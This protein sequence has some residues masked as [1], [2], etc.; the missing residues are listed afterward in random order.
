MSHTKKPSKLEADQRK[1]VIDFARKAPSKNRLSQRTK[2]SQ[3]FGSLPGLK[4]AAYLEFIGDALKIDD[5][6]FRVHEKRAASGTVID[7]KEFINFGSYDYLALNGDVRVHQAAQEAIKKYGVSASA[8]RLVA[9]ERP[10]HTALEQAL[11]EHYKVEDAIVFVSGHATNVSTIGTLMTDKDLVIHDAYAHDSIMVGIKLSGATRRSFKHNDYDALEA[12]LESNQGLFKNTMVCVEGLYSMDGD[13]C[14]LP[15]LLEL[16]ERFGFWLMVDEA[17]SIGTVGRTGGGVAEHFD[18]DPNKVD[19]WMGTLSKTLG[20]TGGYIAG[21]KDLVKYLKLYAPGFVFSVGLSPVLAEAARCALNI[22]E[23]EP[24]RIQKL[25]ENCAYFLKQAEKR[26]LPTGTA[27]GFCVI[28]IQ[29]GDS[30]SAGRMS[31]YLFKRGFN[32][33]PIVYPAVPMNEARLRFF[34]TS[35]HSFE[36]IDQVL[37]AV[38]EGIARPMELDV[39]PE[40]LAQIK[41]NFGY[42][43]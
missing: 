7:G 21:S 28:P 5:P 37:D 13:L 16:K 22:L 15:K 43:L 1:R 4:E 26:N 20:S 27:E 3:S 23:K 29:I 2:P 18:I 9:G 14:D 10:C 36:Q 32:V 30:L 34:L 35:E 6:F 33:L 12:L 31:D 41:K 11:A 40:I 39:D 8:S 24:N 17:H 38:A 25:H 19:I 42:Q